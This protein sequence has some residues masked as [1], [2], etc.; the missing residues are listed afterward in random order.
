MCINEPFWRLKFTPVERKH[1]V[2]IAVQYF[3]SDTKSMLAY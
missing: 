2:Y 1:F 3:Q